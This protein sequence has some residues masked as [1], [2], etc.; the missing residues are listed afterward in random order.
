M[1][2]FFR[3]VFLLG[4]F[5][6]TLVTGVLF[7]FYDSDYYLAA[8]RDKYNYLRVTKSPRI[9]FTGGSNLAFG[10]D[11]EKI[12]KHLGMPVVNMGLSA[13]L[14]LKF[15]LNEIAPVLENGDIVVLVPEY[16]QFH[17]IPLEGSSGDL[18]AVGKYCPEC[19]LATKDPQQII[20][21]AVGSFE[22]IE[23]EIIRTLEP[24]NQIYI[25]RGFNQR[26]D[27]EWRVAEAEQPPILNHVVEIDLQKIDPA[28]DF[29]NA[30]QRVHSAKG[31]RFL[32]I[33]PA[34]P[35]SEYRFQKENFIAL[36]TLLRARL[37]IPILGEPKN[38]IY[39]TDMFYDTVYHLDESARALR[40]NQIIEALLAFIAEK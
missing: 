27:M 8:A 17:L 20:L 38:F 13:G 28:V 23:S 1:R 33:Y 31:A 15:M 40:T 6:F 22:T 21:A 39:P 24:P 16:E 2:T 19:I 29:L 7:A 30:F 37:E 32:M 3:N 12:E 34:I 18:G 26:G 36:D 35:A 25:R 9:I 14:G 5:V 11:S 4:I 10:L